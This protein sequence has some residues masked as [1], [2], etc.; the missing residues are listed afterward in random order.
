MYVLYF[1]QV[2]NCISCISQIFSNVCSCIYCISQFFLDVLRCISKIFSDVL[3]CISCISQ[4]FADNL[5]SI[6]F[7]SQFFSDVLKC[8]IFDN[9]S[10]ISQAPDILSRAAMHN[11]YFICHNVQVFFFS[12]D[13][14][15]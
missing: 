14:S 9:I 13:I 5:R 1:S 4:I 12:M 7:I 10:F 2:L 15:F 3:R 11:A 6:Y 8:T